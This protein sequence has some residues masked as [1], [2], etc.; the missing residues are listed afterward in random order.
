MCRGYLAFAVPWAIFYLRVARTAPTPDG[1]VSMSGGSAK[2][3]SEGPEGVQQR[4]YSS[5]CRRRWG[6]DLS[7]L[8]GGDGTTI[9]RG[10]SVPRVGERWVA[11]S[12]WRDATAGLR[13][14]PSR[15]GA[16]LTPIGRHNRRA[17]RT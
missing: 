15:G 8:G 3:W 2:G 17:S 14:R 7:S 5:W 10:S 16:G 12:E 9:V 4:G 13:V 6:D 1:W 11:S